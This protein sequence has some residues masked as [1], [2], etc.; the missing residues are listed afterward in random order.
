LASRFWQG[1]SQ[2]TALPHPHHQNRTPPIINLTAPRAPRPPSPAPS[3]GQRRCASRPVST[4]RM[5]RQ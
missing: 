5:S 4:R 2:L 1:R 3:A